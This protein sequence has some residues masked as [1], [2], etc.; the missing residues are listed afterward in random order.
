MEDKNIFPALKGFIRIDDNAVEELVNK[1]SGV[2]QCPPHFV[3]DAH[4]FP[5]VSKII[6]ESS[7]ETGEYITSSS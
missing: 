7:I 1:K 2:L 6:N 5:S 4:N 3:D